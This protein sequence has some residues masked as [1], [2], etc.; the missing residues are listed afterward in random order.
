MQDRERCKSILAIHWCDDCFYNKLM[1]QEKGRTLLLVTTVHKQQVIAWM[2]L[3]PW[4]KNLIFW[5]LNYIPFLQKAQSSIQSEL[6]AHTQLT[7]TLISAERSVISV[8]EGSISLLH[9]DTHT[10]TP[11]WTLSTKR[12]IKDRE[13]TVTHT[14]LL[15]SDKHTN[16]HTSHTCIYRRELFSSEEEQETDTLLRRTQEVPCQ[17]HTHRATQDSQVCV[18]FFYQKRRDLSQR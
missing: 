16:T 6:W 14:P 18:F 8:C 13:S 4:K 17:T 11:S 15:L 1:N 2:T 7:H 12:Q 10:H 5:H 3:S 9:T